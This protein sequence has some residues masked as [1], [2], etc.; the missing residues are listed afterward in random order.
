MCTALTYKYFFGRTLDVEQSY[1]EKIVI[2]PRHYTF[3]FKEERSIHTHYTMIGVAK[4]INGYPL[5]FDATNEKGLSMAGLN[6]PENAYYFLKQENKDNITPFEFIPWI[7]SQCASVKEAKI[8]LNRINIVHI[9]FCHELP[10]APL[11]WMIADQEESITVES[12]K[13][14]L[15]VYENTVG[16]LT[17]NPPF[18][19]QLFNLNNYMHLSRNHPKNTFC[20]SLDLK[21]YSCGMGAMGLPGDLSSLSR[22]IRATYTKMN[23][24]C[25]DNEKDI[26]NQFFHILGTV[27]QTKGCVISTAHHYEMTTYTSCCDMKKGIYYYTTYHNLQIC[28]VDM[29]KE[30]IDGKNL[31]IFPFQQNDNIF[32]QNH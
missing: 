6:F 29:F 28:G 2:T 4:V 22:F 11:H 9:P 25:E 21:T 18:D 5:Y 14:G 8:L 17:N 7:L 27:Q 13:N 31:V 1:D 10:L 20:P 32:I 24:V 12:M 15:K 3:S 23:S 16:V 19:I 26:I 30:D